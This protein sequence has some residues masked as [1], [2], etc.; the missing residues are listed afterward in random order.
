MSHLCQ[1]WEAAAHAAAPYGT[2][3]VC[4]RFGL[5]FGHGG[6]LPMMLLPIRL[7]V[8]GRLGD[9]RQWLSWIHLDDLLRGIAHLCTTRLA[10]AANGMKQQA[11]V[12][13][14]NFTAPESVPQE[15]FARIAADLYHRPHCIPTP[16]FPV[17]LALGEQAD[18][19]L[20]GQRVAPARLQL[21]GFVFRY[22]DLRS[23]IDS[24]R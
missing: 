7:G 17:R 1:E 10:H 5:V 8:G 13:A 14:C 3:V 15:T 20:E 16:A 6:A 24:L 23:A 11:Y 22:P 4:M 9:G 21:E 2:H 19:L 12:E 18:L